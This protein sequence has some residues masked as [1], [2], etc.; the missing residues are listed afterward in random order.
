MW[1]CCWTRL[2]ELITVLTKKTV[3]NKQNFETATLWEQLHFHL[4][5]KFPVQPLKHF[6]ISRK[7]LYF[8]SRN[9]YPF[10]IGE[11]A[12]DFIADFQPSYIIIFLVW[13]TQR[14]STVIVTVC[15]YLLTR[16]WKFC[17]ASEEL[18]LKLISFWARSFKPFRLR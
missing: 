6:L 12:L 9:S 18:R 5:L 15:K 8:V 1:N 14:L 10:F 16:Y 2:L 13:F 3:K 11:V 7:I 17:T 4:F